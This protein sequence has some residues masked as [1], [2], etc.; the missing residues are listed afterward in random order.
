MRLNLPAMRTFRLLL[1]A[2]L[3]GLAL[4]TSQGQKPATPAAPGAD[5]P[6]A[7]VF[8]G[9]L[10]LVRYDSP[11]AQ[12]NGFAPTRMDAAKKSG[13]EA[14]DWPDFTL[15]GQPIFRTT[16]DARVP[17]TLH[18]G[19]E[20]SSPFQL[21]TDDVIQPGNHWLRAME[22][23]DTR[24]HI[25]TAD[26]MARSANSSNTMSGRYELWTF[27][28]RISGEG[29]PG[30]RNVEL[31]YRIKDR[32]VVVYKK[33]GPWRTLTL[34][35]PAN[36]PG[37]Q[38]QLSVDG[39]PPLKFD[40]GLLP[41]KLGSPRERPVQFD[42]MLPGEGP[43]V[44]VFTPA[45]PDVF[46]Y[47]KEWNADA[48]ALKQPT[49]APLKFERPAGISRYIGV[50]IQ[51]SPLTIYAAQLPFN[52]SGG[53]YKQGPTGF[54]GTPEQYAAHL[55]ALGFDAVFDQSGALPDARDGQ[56]FEA[57]AAALARHGVKL[58]LTY[59]SNWMRPTL[60]HPNLQLF[61]HTLPE[62][63]APLYRSLSLASQRYARLPNFLGIS[64][65]GSN[66]GYT[67]E[68]N[69]SPPTPDRP[70][71]EAMIA[72]MGKPQPTVP[73]P[74][75]AGKPQWPF[76][77]P[78]KT[79]E[80][81]LKYVG[82]YDAAFQEYTYFGEAVR[83]A[84]GRLV[85]TS[86]AYGSSPGQGARGGWPW[87][88]LPGRAI[89][90][91][92]NVQQAYDL[93]Q[94][95]AAK[96]MHNV[97]L[98]DRLNSYWDKKT[99]WSLVDN[100]QFLY[101]R[102][103][104]Q[105]ACALALS[106]GVQGLGTNFVAKSS[107]EGARPD[108]VAFQKEM[109]DW[110][111]RFG[112]VYAR[113]EPAPVIGI[114]FGHHQAVLRGVVTEENPD[115]ARLYS[116][117]HE[118]KVT[119][120]L[121]FCHAAGWPA[122]VITYQEIRRGALPAS[123]KAILVVGA[124]KDD[125]SWE[126]GPGLDKSLQPFL[127]R[128]GRIITDAESYSP[129]PATKTE[130]RVAAYVSQ[131]N[132]DATPLLLKRNA[133]NIEKLRAAM[134]GVSPPLVS[135]DSQTVWAIAGQTGD[136][137]YVTVV[138]QGFA[139]GDEAKQLLKPADARA[140]R[141]EVWKTKANA[142]LYVKPQTGALKWKTS[143]PVYDLRL[144]RKVTPDEAATVDL[145][146]DAFQFYAL[147]PAEIGTPE[148]S[149][150]KSA[151]GYYEASVK[152]PGGAGG[153]NVAGVPIQLTVTH[154]KETATIFTASG[155]P[156]RLPLH[157]RDTPGEYQLTATE[158]LSGL[159]AQATVQISAPVSP[160]IV[161]SGVRIRDAN[162][163]SKFAARQ[164]NPLVIALTPEQQ[165]DGRLVGQAKALEAF[166]RKANGKRPVALGVAAPGGI[167]EMLQP[168]KTP[169]RFPQWKTSAVDVVLFGTPA[170]NV[171]LL[172]QQRGEILPWNFR[173]PAPGQAEVVYTRSPF[174]GECEVLNIIAPDV[175]GIA[176]A[177]QTLTA[178]PAAPATPTVIPTVA[179]PK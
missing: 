137:Q 174:V 128:G 96:P 16:A 17:L 176:A 27:P 23:R 161:Q 36:E 73:R 22:W 138:N 85:F 153:R 67:S 77:Y 80:E 2:L 148:V 24:R 37:V 122:R 121:F 126:W 29:G 19:A 157:E 20:A 112:G 58:G 46:P 54:E 30:V 86:G 109:H 4:A 91:G 21:Q 84:A 93:N 12:S 43:K 140:T 42:R 158:L 139:E 88:S 10:S 98:T 14:V 49:P 147:P 146:K 164:V 127:A 108:V 175:N 34:L 28:L 83:E 15:N 81:F 31:K 5:T 66:S 53:F 156:A 68:W 44:R 94:T 35:L 115:D 172:D 160:T 169:H 113:L 75:A 104:Y 8:I 45:R 142:S 141:P 166:Y 1:P 63:H 62:W 79:V 154:D 110:A 60:Q 136:V 117:S 101:G 178:P 78:A 51:R 32:D 123:M 125:Q 95:R 167:V 118:G 170:N 47:T 111:H 151:S 7:H 9:L 61:S 71:G 144:G 55:A 3:A 11:I 105:R 173:V 40:I 82:R 124:P 165:K 130:M 64:V 65:G 25:Y 50:E 89:F 74:P 99:T 179:R 38:Y 132:L 57:R 41:V 69:P 106:R 152:L 97:A 39:R 59:D 162:A 155:E 52:Q 163:V 90:S 70:W 33:D 102:E 145:T 171:L 92:L 168:L 135:T 13:E 26:R 159:S 131:S 100:F 177:V 149:V 107:G 143:R 114:F 116:G 119:E 18:K 134:E 72:F 129:V 6:P 150:V 133:G 56:S 103:A 48:S 120:A 76:E 87:G